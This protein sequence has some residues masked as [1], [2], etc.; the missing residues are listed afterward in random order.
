MEHHLHHINQVRSV[1][2]RAPAGETILLCL[3]HYSVQHQTEHTFYV[4]PY[5]KEQ[6]G[7]VRQSDEATKLLAQCLWYVVVM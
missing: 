1:F 4:C 5:P 7:R 6:C 3:G 2:T